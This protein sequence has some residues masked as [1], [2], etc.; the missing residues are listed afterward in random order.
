MRHALSWAEDGRDWPNRET[1]RFVEAGG[2]TWH[3]QVAGRGP[4]LLLLH[5]TGASTHSW[6]ALLPSLATRFTVVAPDLPG[7]AFTSVEPPARMS[8]P[9]MATGVS[10]LLRR[11]DLAPRLVVGHSAGA[12][13]LAWMTL[14]QMIDPAGL[15]SLNGALLPIGGV[16][17]RVFS[18]LAKL[19]AGSATMS[20]LVARWAGDDATIGRLIA[21]TG[22]RLDREG[23]VLYRRLAGN[24]SHAGAALA[25]MAHWDLE[26]LERRLP[27]LSTP[28][29]LVVGTKDGSIAPSDADRVRRLVPGSAIERLRGLGHLAHEEAPDLVVEI[30]LRR[31]EG[32]GVIPRS[33]QTPSDGN[34]S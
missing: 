28:V 19:V 26:R 7:H 10:A 17:G 12:A 31:A 1:S 27:G 15:I 24:R 32:W 8:M 2:L 18:P 11:L 3:V 4:P 14:E 21:Q 20:G 6:R 33:D 5:G 30:I 22:S 23:L 16:A 9:G 13:I 34:R 29:V 25:M